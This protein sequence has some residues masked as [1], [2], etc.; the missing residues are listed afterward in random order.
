VLIFDLDGTLID[1]RRDIAVACNHALRAVGRAPLDEDRVASFVGDGAR[2]VVERA[3]G[4]G[5][6]RDLVERTLETFIAYYLEHPADY[7][8]IMPGAIEALD[9]LS[10][11]PLAVATNKRRDVALAVLDA[12]GLSSR[13]R[14]IWGGGDG[15]PKP[16]PACVHALL[17]QA[18]IPH[19]DAWMIGDGVQDIGAGKAAGVR[20][21]AVLGG[22]QKE[23]SLRALAPDFVIRS[24]GELPRLVREE[25]AALRSP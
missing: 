20:T 13:F 7:T 1:S 4:W 3:L 21:V 2:A 23:P 6:D 11:R 18:R 8:T 5:A 16:D 17:A 24:L 25:A 9:A 15:A 19:R 10:D 22:F 14:W 12:L